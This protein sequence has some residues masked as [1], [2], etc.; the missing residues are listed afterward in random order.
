[1]LQ[2]LWVVYGKMPAQKR[3]KAS[4]YMA[5]KADHGKISSQ[6]HSQ[7]KVQCDNFHTTGKF[8]STSIICRLHLE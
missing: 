7:P 1:M 4:D 8:F 3:L 6:H 2:V 5:G